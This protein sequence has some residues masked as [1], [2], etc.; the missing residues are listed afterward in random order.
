MSA[1]HFP[2]GLYPILDLDACRNRN[3]NP[4][5]IILQWKKLG[6][7]PY[8]LRAKSLQAEEYAAMAEHL[9]ARWISAES[10]GENRWH[11]RPA[12]IAN[13][14]LEVAWHHSDWFCGIHLGRSDLQSLSP[15]EEQML[16]QIL[17]SGGVAGCSTH[18][19]E[20]FRNALE[21][22]RGG[23][24]WSY[25]ALGP[26]F[27]SDSKTNSLDQNP[28]L[29]VEKVSEIVADPALS[30]VLSGRQIRSTAVL[31]G[32]LDPDRWRALREAT[33]QRNVEELSLVPA[34]IAS[35]L[36]GA[37]RWNEALEGHS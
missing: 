22:K 20:E 26:V 34:A 1:P 24:G 14:F 5:E 9:H 23:T 8:Q 31:I 19:A 2:A 17:D 6:W 35:V 4:D 13:D 18:T 29:G 3:L 21:E 10:G 7:G 33:E 11:S 15:R 27:S 16:G 36:D 37:Q 32:G 12:I 30:D 25:V 28:A